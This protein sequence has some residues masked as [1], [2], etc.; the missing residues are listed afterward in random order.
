VFVLLMV[1]LKGT[2]VGVSLGMLFIQVFVKSADC[3]GSPECVVMHTS[4]CHRAG[5]CSGN[6]LDLCSGG[7]RFVSRSVHHPS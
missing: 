1:E 6:A 2:N 4:C 7:A 5:Q 3:F